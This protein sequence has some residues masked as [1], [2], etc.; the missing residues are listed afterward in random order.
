MATIKDVARKA[1][2][3]I[4]TVDRV[5][6]NRGR[7]SKKTNEKVKKI[8]EELGYKPNLY[9]RH[10]SLAKLYTFGV[11]M[12]MPEQDSG[13]WDLSVKGIERAQ[14]A[15]KP[16]HVK[17][18]FYHYDRHDEQSFIEQCDKLL[19]AKHDGI[20]IA[21]VV[22]RPVRD[23]F[24]LIPQGIPYVLFNANIPDINATSFI[25]QDSYQSGFVCGKLMNMMMSNRKCTA[26]VLAMYDDYH[27]IERADGFKHYFDGSETVAVKMY[28]LHKNSTKE[29][30]Y[31][32]LDEIFRENSDLGGIFVTNAS[33]HYVAEYLKEKIGVKKIG[34]IGYDL[35]DSNVRYLKEGWVD[36]LISQKAETQ[37][38]EG[39][40]VLYREVVLQQSCARN[41]LM[42][43]DVVMKEN[44]VYYV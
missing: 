18:K 4:G 11:L 34:L 9:A 1:K 10:L 2:V 16:Y 6:H 43:I 40:Y 14:T 44:L 41:I 8:V 29:S 30:F 36:F 3:S 23:F 38:Y 7:V 17:V 28:S 19:K 42:P 21:P 12:P 22:W 37:G 24:K 13:Y 35:I 15:L 26:A 5:V 25:G 32:T 33:T 27:I 31:E 20:L 39:I